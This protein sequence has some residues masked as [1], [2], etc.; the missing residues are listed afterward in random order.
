MGAQARNGGISIHGVRYMDLK[1]TPSTVTVVELGVFPRGNIVCNFFSPYR[2]IYWLAGVFDLDLYQL[3]HIFH[4]LGV[5]WLAITH[6]LTISAVL[7][8]AGHQQLR[9][10]AA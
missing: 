6:L 5:A 1:V 4:S 7:G 2:H 9:N 10:Q 8:E 3:V